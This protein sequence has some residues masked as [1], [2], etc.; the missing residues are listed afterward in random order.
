VHLSTVFPWVR[1]R[2]YLEIRA[3]DINAPAIV[4]AITALVKGLFYS[5]S[6][7]NAVEALVGT[8]DKATVEALLR[9]PCTMVWM[10]K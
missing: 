5:V 2:H 3:F 6:S 10:R 9:R 1:L 8:Y 4:L 7:L